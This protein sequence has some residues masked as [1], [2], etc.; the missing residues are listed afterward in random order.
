MHDFFPQT[1]TNKKTKKY[2]VLKLY[3]QGNSF[4][5]DPA[6]FKLYNIRFPLIWQ[7]IICIVLEIYKSD[8]LE[9]FKSCSFLKDLRIT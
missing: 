7:Q 9:V 6:N 5:S 4:W 1:N 3:L 8:I 2:T